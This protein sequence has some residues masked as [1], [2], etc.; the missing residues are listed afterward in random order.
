MTL[1]QR[2]RTID[3]SKTMTIYNQRISNAS[4]HYGKLHPEKIKKI[5]R[6]KRKKRKE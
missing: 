6:G 2:A 4:F 5:N 1:P 3:N